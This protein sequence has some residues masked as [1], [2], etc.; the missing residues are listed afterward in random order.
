MNGVDAA[1]V[2]RQ[3]EVICASDAGKAPMPTASSEYYQVIF[4]GP[5][6]QQVKNWAEQANAHGIATSFAAQLPPGGRAPFK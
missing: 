3:V 4:P 2:L 5:I 1:E 6:L